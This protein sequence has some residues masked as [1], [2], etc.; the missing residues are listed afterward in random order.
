MAVT[1][2]VVTEPLARDLFGIGERFRNR[3]YGNDHGDGSEAG[4]TSIA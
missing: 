1:L 2:S 4:R 3:D